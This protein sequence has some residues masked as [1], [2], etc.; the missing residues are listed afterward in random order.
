[1]RRKK[2]RSKQGQTNK[3]GKAT[4]HTQGSHFHMYMYLDLHSLMS[5]VYMFTRGLLHMPAAS[6][7]GPACVET[8]AEVGST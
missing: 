8:G 7:E 6:S 4:Q 3:Q 1:M 2:E 5:I